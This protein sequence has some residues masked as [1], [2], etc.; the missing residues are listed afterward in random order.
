MLFLSGPT[1]FIIYDQQE[2]SPHWGLQEG[3]GYEDADKEKE[4]EGNKE[5]RTEENN[6]MTNKNRGPTGDYRRGGG[7]EDSDKKKKEIKKKEL[8]GIMERPTRTEAPLG[9][10]GGGI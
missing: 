1:Q 9:I 6:G 10:T 7:Y 5:E 4:K 8:M 3:G 2:P